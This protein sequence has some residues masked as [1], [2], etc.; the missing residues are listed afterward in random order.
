MAS[1][2][3]TNK[4]TDL[5]QYWKDAKDFI[6]QIKI[7]E[8]EE[9]LK[10]YEIEQ[11]KKEKEEAKQNKK[12]EKLEKKIP[13]RVCTKC[14]KTYRTHEYFFSVLCDDCIVEEKKEIEEYNGYKYCD[15][16][17]T[18]HKQ[19]NKIFFN[20]NCEICGR[21]FSTTDENIDICKSYKCHEKY[22]KYNKFTKL[23]ETII[24]YIK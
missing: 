18:I 10:E 24:K 6:V 15:Y 22:N 2:F 7:K 17:K 4:F 1:L 13:L 11:R 8:R 16:N 23:Y 3:M 12:K 21:A 14:G 9:Y 20:K 5:I 19:Q